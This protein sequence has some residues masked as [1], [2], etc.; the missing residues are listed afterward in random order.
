MLGRI[1][2]NIASHGHHVTLVQAGR[3]PRFAYTIGLTDSGRPEAVL[4]GASSLSGRDVKQALDAAAAAES[5][6]QAAVL[7]VAGVGSFTLAPVHDSW[8][9]RLLLGVFDF[10]GLDDVEAVQLAPDEDLRTIDVPDL[11]QP[12]DPTSQPVWQWF[13]E[14]WRYDAPPEAVAMTNLDALR[15]QPITEAARWEDA[16]WEMFA[17]AGPDVSPVDVRAVPLSTLIG[18]DPS[19]EPVVQL[20]VGDALRRDP[21]GDWEAW[22]SE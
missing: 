22:G 18:F 10:Y 1:R 21:G 12:W 9:R 6:D 5:L 7:E 2:A 4:A 19:L 11:S 8:A 20:G 16:E 17:G 13:D 15:G 14:P 3:A